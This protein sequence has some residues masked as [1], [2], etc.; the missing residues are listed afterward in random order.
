MLTPPATSASPAMI[1][2]QLQ[3][4]S[5][6]QDEQNRLMVIHRDRHAST[7]RDLSGNI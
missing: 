5:A 2:G 1:V 6:D 3:R 7:Q 4:S